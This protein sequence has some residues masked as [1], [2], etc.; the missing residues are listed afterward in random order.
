MKARIW[1]ARGSLPVALNHKQIRAKLVTA[2]EGAIGRGLDTPEKVADYV[3]HE[4]SFE[5]RGTYGGNSSCVEVE[6]WDADAVHEHIILDLGSGV[7]PLAGAKLARYG[8]AQPQTYHVFLSHLHWDHIMGFPFFTPAYIPG[9]R[10]IIY[11]CHQ[12]LEAALRRQQDP[13]SFPVPFDQMAAD[14]SFV[15]MTPGVPLQLRD[16]TV[17]AKL[18]LHGGDSYGYRLEQGGKAMI[19]TT[20]SEHKLDNAAE[21]AGFVE[22]FRDADLVIFDAMYSLEESISVKADWGHSS[23][24]VGVE[25]CQLAGVRQLCLFHHEPVYDDARISRVLAET[26]RYAKVTCEAPLEI[27]SAYDGMEITL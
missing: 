14:I 12:E 18:Q 11:G 19:Y 21:L 1:G 8:A 2:L 3:D 5:V 16:V 10:I 20:D 24:V 4:L 15:Q 17:T 9:N 23:N 7:R 13:I 6:A 27:V 26:R 25:L 22:F